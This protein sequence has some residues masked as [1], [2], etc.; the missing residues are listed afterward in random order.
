LVI[1]STAAIDPAIE[2][3]PVTMKL[4]MNVSIVPVI[5]QLTAFANDRP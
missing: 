3:F 5:R 2:A 1:N 4:M